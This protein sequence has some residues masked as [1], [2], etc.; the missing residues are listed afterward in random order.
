MGG[1]PALA[2]RPQEGLLQQ[3]GQAQQIV[4]GQ[5]EAQLRA[6]QVQ[7]AQRALT[8]QHALTQ[9]M[10]SYDGKNPDQLPM[11]VL[12]AGGSG[13]AALGMSKNVLGIKQTASE[14][15]KNDSITGQNNAKAAA[16]AND[17]YRGRLQSIIGITDPVQKQAAWEAEITKEEQSGQIQPG[18]IPHTYIGDDKATALANHFALGSQ[19]AK[20]S[21]ERQRR[22]IDAWKNVGGRLVNAI[23]HEEIGG[24]SN[25][26][27]LNAGI[28]TR[29]QVLHP[30]EKAPDNFHLPPTATPA[31]FERIDKLMEATERATA[32]KEQQN[33]TNAIR[34][35]TM[36][37]ARDKQDLQAVVGNDPKTGRSV[38]VPMGQ[39]QQMGLTD[40][41]KAPE[42]TINKALAAR[43]WLTL[44]QK[45]APADAKPEEMGIQ[46]LIDKLDADGKLGPL[47]SRWNEF[48]SGK[49]GAGDPDYSALR[50]KMG[51]S[52]TLLMQAHVGSRGSSQMLEHFEDLANAKKLDGP[53]LKT[54]VGSEVDYVKDRAMDP[55][56]PTY[57]Q[58][59]A[60][61]AP[62]HTAGG[63][64]HGLKEGQTGTG[65]D[66]KKY[67]VRG[68]KW[69]AVQ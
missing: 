55:N 37:M 28:D 68:G 57:S 44:A 26:P 69:E 7:Q 30:G 3:Y 11:L 45:Q 36:E 50:T 59:K 29:W 67:V 53:T 18:S 20:E 33:T 49:F 60:S 2:I 25:I 58:P 66:G 41:M 54:S 38:M 4:A 10:Q 46:Q 15:A 42:D 12:R 61:A 65:S 39:A 43:H 34:A 27:V 23:T 48:M 21:D 32:T 56:P 9:A 24:L 47:A 35:Q 16:E 19:L 63:A 64:A 40:A 5:Q 14:I 22:S 13:Q 8:D 17:Q 31:D 51:L 52:T 62:Q 6:L 1:Y